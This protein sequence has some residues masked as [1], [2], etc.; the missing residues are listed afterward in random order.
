MLTL[1]RRSVIAQFDELFF[2]SRHVHKHDVLL[3][4]F[5]GVSGVLPKGCGKKR[6][7]LTPKA[8]RPAAQEIAK[9]MLESHCSAEHCTLCSATV[10][11]PVWLPPCHRMV[12]RHHS[13]LAAQSFMDK[14]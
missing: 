13:Y 5:Q 2:C 3:F 10:P 11:R 12:S 7:T 4:T 14:P 6:Y 9:V 8:A 1:S